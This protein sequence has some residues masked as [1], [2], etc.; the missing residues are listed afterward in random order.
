MKS[1]NLQYSPISLKMLESIYEWGKQ[2]SGT[3]AAQKFVRRIVDDVKRLRKA[4]MI[5]SHEPLLI[6]YK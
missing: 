3:K 5:G 6:D 1:Y 4:P 2:D